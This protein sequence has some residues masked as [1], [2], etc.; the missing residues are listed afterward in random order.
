MNDPLDELVRLSNNTVDFNYYI[1]KIPEHISASNDKWFL[2]KWREDEITFRPGHVID[3]HE[4]IWKEIIGCD[5]NP[6]KTV[7]PLQWH[8]TDNVILTQG[9]SESIDR[10]IGAVSTTIDWASIGTDA[11][12]ESEAQTDL[13]AEDSGGSYARKQISTL[14]QR[15]RVN[16]TAKYGMVWDDGDISGTGLAIKEAGLHWNVSASSKCHCRI[17]FTT[18]T[19][20]SGDLFVSQINE[21]HANGTL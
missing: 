10:D 4:K 6:R 17:S 16:Q 13:I 20:N 19:L 15:T 21:T 3:D 18:F 1:N 9:M 7:M 11:T 14:G 5:F 12:A 2:S 8:V